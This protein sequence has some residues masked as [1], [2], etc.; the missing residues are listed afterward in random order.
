MDYMAPEMIQNKPHDASLDIWCLGVLLYELVHGYEPFRG[1][2]ETEKCANIVNNAG[3]VFDRTISSDCQA[4]IR[5]ILKTNPRE[6][7]SIS[8]IFQH[9]WMQYHEKYFGIHLSDYILDTQQQ[10]QQGNNSTTNTNESRGPSNGNAANGQLTEQR[11]S[12][13]MFDAPPHFGPPV[14]QP[15]Y[16]PPQKD[17]SSTSAKGT[18][19]LYTQEFTNPFTSD[20]NPNAPP[21]FEKKAVGI[22]PNAESPSKLQHP[23]TQKMTTMPDPLDA[24]ISSNQTMGKTSVNAYLEE[25]KLRDHP[26][27]ALLTKFEKTLTKTSQ[28]PTHQQS[29]LLT[30]QTTR[31]VPTSS[32]MGYTP[33][34]STNTGNGAEEYRGGY[35]SKTIEQP[36]LSE[37]TQ[38]YLKY[39]KPEQFPITVAPPPPVRSNQYAYGGYHDV[40]PP[41]PP[42]YTT[43]PQPATIRTNTVQNEKE[44]N[45]RHGKS[46]E[47]TPGQVFNNPLAGDQRKPQDL[48]KLTD[49]STNN[50]QTNTQVQ[51]RY[52]KTKSKSVYYNDMELADEDAEQRV[53]RIPA[54]KQEIQTP[55]ATTTQENVSVIDRILEAF[56]CISRDKP[57]DH[58][59][60]H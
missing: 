54:K 58:P 26:E 37:T 2:T 21:K 44:S 41:Q 10:A 11:T 18:A 19:P 7:P 27:I 42:A 16:Q 23:P 14:T 43:T 33:A 34:N 59:S 22:D 53:S 3:I 30:S 57:H 51:A 48:D 13:P 47:Y 39:L 8:E 20:V 6:R 24:R 36:K 55:K 35:T 46:M 29:P 60:H 49:A 15:E 52:T 17:A 1:K 28:D 31:Q 45:G 32:Q 40:P 5:S 9:T 50:T 25:L 56:G 38:L 12:D 4:L